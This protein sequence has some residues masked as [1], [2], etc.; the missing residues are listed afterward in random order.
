MKFLLCIWLK[1]MKIRESML[2]Y[3]RY[4]IVMILTTQ[5][6][7]FSFIRAAEAAELRD[8]FSFCSAGIFVLDVL[9][10]MRYFFAAWVWKFSHFLIDN[11]LIVMKKDWGK[12]LISKLKITSFLIASVGHFMEKINGVHKNISFSTNCTA[13]SEFSIKIR[14]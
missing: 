4:I 8:G 12:I 3:T 2:M 10:H 11:F 5:A 9:W 14:K 7:F 1:D 6:H 13:I